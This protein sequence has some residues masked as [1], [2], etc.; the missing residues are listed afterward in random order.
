MTR[1]DGYDVGGG[2]GFFGQRVQ[3]GCFFRGAC[4]AAGGGCRGAGLA[5]HSG[6]RGFGSGQFNAEVPAATVS[7]IHC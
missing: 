2:A 5:S 3:N 7:S 4:A 1:R 6:G